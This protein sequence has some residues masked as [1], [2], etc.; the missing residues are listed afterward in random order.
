MWEIRCSCSSCLNVELCLTKAPVE[1]K[2]TFK[3][4]GKKDVENNRSDLRKKKMS[5]EES[6]LRKHK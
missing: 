2:D 3:K 6:P 4:R 1:R 5:Y